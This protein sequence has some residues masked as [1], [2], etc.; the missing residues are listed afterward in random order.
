MPLA[1]PRDSGSSPIALPA[2]RVAGNSDAT[3]M[4]S[5]MRTKV[6]RIVELADLIA[7]DIRRRKLNPGDS[8]QSTLETAEM[9]GVSTTAANR[10]MQVL[11]KR[12]VLDRRQ[13]KGTFEIG[14]A[15]CRERVKSS[16]VGG[17]VKK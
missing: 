13:K 8:Y 5:R 12:R 4:S 2:A 15:S 16:V 1:P 9:L 3:R 7:A 14:R 10:A 17:S 6:P 11:V